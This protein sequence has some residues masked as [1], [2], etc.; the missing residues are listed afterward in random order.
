MKSGL[1]LPSLAFAE[2]IAEEWRSQGE[3]LKPAAMPLTQLANT[4]IDRVTPNPGPT[5]DELM[6]YAGPALTC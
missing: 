1:L 6:G 4:A 5:I 3:R 2:A